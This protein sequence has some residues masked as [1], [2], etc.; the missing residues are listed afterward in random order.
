METWT[1]GAD[2]RDMRTAAGMSQEEAASALGVRLGTYGSWERGT[3]VPRREALDR[4]VEVFGVP[5]AS[6]GL[7]TPRGWELVPADWIR[8]QIAA[9][10]ERARVR[11]EEVLAQLRVLEG[12]G[13]AARR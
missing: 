7:D 10:E 9:Q 1:Y 12:I 6:L 4:I 13:R 11:H 5:P 8:D 2:L 3:H